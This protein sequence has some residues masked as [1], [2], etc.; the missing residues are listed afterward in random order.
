MKQEV[1]RDSPPFNAALRTASLPFSAIPRQSRLFLDYLRDPLFQKKYYP[2][3]VEKPS[4]VDDYAR[5][6]LADYST[7]RDELCDAL[8]EINSHATEKT[9]ENIHLLREADTVAVV[10]GQQAGLFTGPLYTIYKAI[11]AIKMAEA[12]TKR[13]INAVPVF[14]I[15]TEDHDF[16]EVSEANFLASSGEVFQTAYRPKSYRENLPVGSVEIDQGIALL[17]E[18]VFADLP[19]TEFS[20]EA[21]EILAA[22]WKEGSSFGEAFAATLSRLLGKFGL[23]IIDPMNEQIKQLAAP[24]YA[25]A[26]RNADAITEAD[27]TRSRDLEVE[28]YHAQVAVEENYFPLFWHD[29]NGERKALR[30]VRDDVYSAKGDK[31]EFDLAEL[32]CIAKQ[33][34]SRFSPGVMLRSVAQDFLLPTACYFGGGAEIAYFAQNSE[35]YRILNR[36]VTPIFHRHSFTIVEAKQRRAMEKLGIEFTD[37]FDGLEKVKLTVGEK[38]IGNSTALLFTEAEERINEELNILDQ[39][40]S[41]IDVTLADNLAKRRRKIVYHIAALRKKTLLAQVRK[42]ETTARQIDGVFASLYPEGQLQER[43]VN[44]FTYL[45]RYGINF[46]DWLYESVDLD[47]KGHRIVN[48]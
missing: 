24:I 12:M 44:V 16:D 45:N 1:A 25:N 19:T 28:G 38:N 3:A 26:I 8:V 9:L 27:R 46:I 37:L 39:A 5:G 11:S 7:D 40:V 30:K 10:T 35:V 21:R 36:P 29:E 47:D 18:R 31:R 32:E 15:A 6:V 41:Q 14:W 13:G 2:N 17:I 33:E 20:D 34:P 48:L 22:S 4:G 42:D 23:I 43:T